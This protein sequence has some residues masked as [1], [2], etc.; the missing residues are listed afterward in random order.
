MAARRCSKF[1]PIFAGT[2]AN[3]CR[4]AWACIRN[5]VRSVRRSIIDLIPGPWYGLP[6]PLISQLWQ[7]C[8][9]TVAS[10][11]AL[12]RHRQLGRDRHTT[13]LAALGTG[14]PANAKLDA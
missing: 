6:C 9:A 10:L 11:V 4:K 1:Q 3:V 8:I 13:R 5:P 7:I 12:D 14:V 2:V